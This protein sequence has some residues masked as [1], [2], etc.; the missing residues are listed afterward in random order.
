MTI[1]KFAILQKGKLFFLDL[2]FSL[3]FKKSIKAKEIKIIL[4]RPKY[5][6]P[7]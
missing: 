4:P 6:K 3:F 5:I 7:S 2:F 1:Y